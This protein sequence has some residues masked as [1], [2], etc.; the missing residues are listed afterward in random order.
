M[1]IDIRQS[2]NAAYTKTLDTEG[3]RREFLAGRR[4]DEQPGLGGQRGR[5]GHLLCRGQQRNKQ[6]SQE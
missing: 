1:Q 2:C 3:L 6:K 5:G 4:F